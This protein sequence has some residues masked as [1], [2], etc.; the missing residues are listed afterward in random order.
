[1]EIRRGTVH[2]ADTFIQEAI[3][4]AREERKRVDRRVQLAALSALIPLALTIFTLAGFAFAGSHTLEADVA[5]TSDGMRSLQVICPGGQSV[6]HGRVLPTATTASVVALDL[7]AGACGTKP[8]TV[9]LQRS[10]IA[11]LRTHATACDFRSG[12][13]WR[14]CLLGG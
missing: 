3:G 2:G 10:D 13:G 1:M 9:S 5:L 7:P 8:V 11:A 14:V 12:N 6:L 4:R